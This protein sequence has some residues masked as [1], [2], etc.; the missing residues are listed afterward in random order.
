MNGVEILSTAEVV[1]KWAFGWSGFW[2]ASSIVAPLCTVGIFAL[3]YKFERNSGF[4]KNITFS[5]LCGVLL[6]PTIGLL[7]GQMS[8]KPIEYETQYKVT[9]SDEV[10]F[11]EF[12]NKYEIVS[13][14]DKIFTVREK[15]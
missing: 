11:N 1:T 14:E 12:Y 4:V 13:Q 3:L 2:I 5:I 9:I 10:N 6:G 15:K 7:C 8:A